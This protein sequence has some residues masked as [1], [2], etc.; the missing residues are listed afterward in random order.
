MARAAPD[1]V[2]Y[3]RIGTPSIPRHEQHD[4]IE[5][6]LVELTNRISKPLSYAMFSHN[7]PDEQAREHEGEDDSDN[8][9]IL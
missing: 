1:V 5:Q 3:C 6:L 4:G 8:Y 7:S 2:D 9:L